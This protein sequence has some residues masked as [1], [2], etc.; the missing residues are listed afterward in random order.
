MYVD[1]IL[2]VIKKGSTEKL[3]EFLNSL[4]ATGSIKFTYEVKQDNCDKTY[5]PAAVPRHS[6]GKNGQRW[7]QAM[8]PQEAHSYRP[9]SHF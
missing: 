1:D 6:V 3:S 8:Q 7:P 2:E 4:D 5:V 9:L